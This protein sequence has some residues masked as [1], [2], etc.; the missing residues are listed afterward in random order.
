ML[1]RSLANSDFS[2]TTKNRIFVGT[3]AATIGWTTAVSILSL[4]GVLKD[5]SVFPPRFL[6]VLLVPLITM[7]AVTFLPGTSRLLRF[8]PATGIIYLQSFRVVVEI[9]LWM[10]FEQ[11]KLPIQL[12]FEGR[13]FDVI[14]GATAPIV[15]YLWSKNVVPKS[16]VIIW[17]FMGLALLINVVATAILSLPTPYRVF[18]NE[19]ANTI[20][21]DFPIIWLP[22]LLVPLA[23][24]LHFL[25]LR[26]LLA[27]DT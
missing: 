19:P 15:A 16:I 12:T 7:L 13:N 11:G 9:L 6:I 24:G 8:F 14:T 5:F 22:G 26:Q 2:S 20:V 18:M 1:K 4:A 3:V 25:S 23:Y 21:A 10:S 27:S 17:N